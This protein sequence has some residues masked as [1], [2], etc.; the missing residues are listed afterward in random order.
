MQADRPQPPRKD[1]WSKRNG[2]K[3]KRITLN[4]RR[5]DTGIERC[6]ELHYSCVVPRPAAYTSDS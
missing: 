2:L 6:K 4:S 3:R 5:N 1:F